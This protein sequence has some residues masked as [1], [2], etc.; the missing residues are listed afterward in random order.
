V[1]PIPGCTSSISGIQLTAPPDGDLALR[2]LR[3]SNGWA[4]S[5]SDRETWQAQ[6]DLARREGI[7]VEPAAAIT[8]AAL[9]ADLAN[10]RLQ[11]HEQVVCWL[12]GIGFK[13]TQAA[14]R[15]A[16]DRPLRLIKVD[17][18][19]QLR[20]VSDEETAGHGTPSG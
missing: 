8:L 16:Q 13:D 15:L 12:T 5:I 9:K 11:G 18:I 14:Q 1:Q 3:E 2:A 20:I 10:G 6:A 7:F 4:I 17:E 19:L